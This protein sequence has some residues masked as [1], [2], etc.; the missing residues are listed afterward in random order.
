MGAYS[1]RKAAYFIMLFKMSG[2]K[3]VQ[4]L[5]NLETKPKI[6]KK[7]IQAYVSKNVHF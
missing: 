6:K 1:S 7:K 2:Y 5:E 4:N 3:N